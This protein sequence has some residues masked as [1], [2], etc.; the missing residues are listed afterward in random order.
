KDHKLIRSGI[1]K[2]VRHPAYTGSILISFGIAI[3]LSSF[4]GLVLTIF[5]G[6]PAK[7]YRIHKE[8]LILEAEFGAEYRK[9][10]EEVKSLIPLVY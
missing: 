5:V 4:L 7:M 9:Y 1:Y 2:L 3:A 10:A 6:L 8:E